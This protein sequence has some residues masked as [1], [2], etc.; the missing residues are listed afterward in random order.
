MEEEFYGVVE[1]S[2]VN[3]FNKNDVDVEDNVEA[4]EGVEDEK[5]E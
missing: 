4:E 2:D 5:E 3:D 1:E